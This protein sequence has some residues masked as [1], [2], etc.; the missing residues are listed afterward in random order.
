MKKLLIV[1]YDP[2]TTS[3]IAVMDT[4]KNVL[5]ITSKRDFIKKEMIDVISEFGKPVFRHRF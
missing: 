5:K 4:K 1:G 3:A 2:G